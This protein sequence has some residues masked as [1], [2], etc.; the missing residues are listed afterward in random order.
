MRHADVATAR[1]RRSREKSAAHVALE[2]E[3]LKSRSDPGGTK[4]NH[5]AFQCKAFSDKQR[6][7][8]PEA[9]KIALELT[10]PACRNGYVADD[11]SIFICDLAR[12]SDPAPIAKSHW[13]K[14]C[15]DEEDS[16]H[17]GRYQRACRFAPMGVTI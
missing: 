7:H 4:I 16:F 12:I 9:K 15:G 3:K 11:A 17:F 13:Q 1:A 5:L 8:D 10:R 6:Q 2:M 14:S